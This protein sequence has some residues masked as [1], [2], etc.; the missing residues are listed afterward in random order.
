[1]VIL[2]PIFEAGA[3]GG[4]RI[5]TSGEVEV[6]EPGRTGDEIRLRGIFSGRLE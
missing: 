5:M 2:T 3:T 6:T 4:L 1:M